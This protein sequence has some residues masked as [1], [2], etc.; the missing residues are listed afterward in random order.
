MRIGEL[1]RRTRV[2][3]RL[4]RYY[5]KQGLL[6]P[7]RRPNGYREYEEADID[8]VRRIRSLL[9]A[10]LSTATIA[11]IQSCIRPGGIPV[12]ACAGV[13]SRLRDERDRVDQA[14][15]HLQTT[16]AALEDIIELGTSPTALPAATDPE[17]PGR[18]P[19]TPWSGPDG[20]R[21]PA[22][23]AGG[24]GARHRAAGQVR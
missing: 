12:P 7:Q 1:A 17:T 21:V 13:I 20:G 15:A 4:L 8:V 3:E 23:F 6:Q 11:E 22:G 9:A 16:R 5:E 18:W 10:G 24:R 19:G 14:I 2:D